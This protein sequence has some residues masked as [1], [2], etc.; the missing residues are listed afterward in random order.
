ML[1]LGGGDGMAV[2]EVLKYP[3]VTN[4]TL[5]DLDPTMTHLFSSQEMLLRL[6]QSALRS[7]RVN[8]V[9]TD[10]FTW[11]KANTNQFDFIAADFP[12]PSTFSVGKL[13][14]TAF[15]A[16]VRAVLRPEGIFV[17]QCTSPWVARKSFWCVDETLRASGFVTEPYHL[18]VPSFGE[19]GFILASHEPRSPAIR[20][21]NDL[22]FITEAGL[23]ELFNFPPDM[24]PVQVEVNR[25]NNQS[26]VRYFEEEWAHYVH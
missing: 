2:R 25:L 16:R 24:S 17:T 1:V 19:W 13:Y 11:L 7:P 4:V 5:V 14:T 9:N 21:P 23:R 6:N 26:L 15:Y 20:L 22:K 12:D 3:S 8:I 10:A 18:Y